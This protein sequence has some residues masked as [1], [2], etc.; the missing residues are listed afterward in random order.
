MVIEFKNSWSEFTRRVF[1]NTSAAMVYESWATQGE[2]EKWFL[3]RAQFYK[4]DGMA[5]SIGESAETGDTFEWEWH[6]WS[7]MNLTG[8][9]IEAVEGEVFHFDFGDAGKVKITFQKVSPN[10]TQVI[11]NQYNI[12]T[13]EFSKKEYYYGCSLGWSFWMLNLKAFLEYGVLLDEK[14]VPFEGDQRHEV[15]NH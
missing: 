7:E 14:D 11:L 4:S 12:P 9:L 15:V 13:D 10:K 2:M 6:T 1:I 5:R 8:K 3:K